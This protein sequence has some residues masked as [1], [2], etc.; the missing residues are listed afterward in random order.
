MHA[1]I[2]KFEN[3]HKNLV[4]VPLQFAINFIFHFTVIKT[5][6][7]RI[8]NSKLEKYVYVALSRGT[9]PIT[10][11]QASQKKKNRQSSAR[12]HQPSARISRIHYKPITKLSLA[13]SPVGR[14][15]TAAASAQTDG[16]KRVHI[17]KTARLSRARYRSAKTPLNCTNHR[18]MTVLGGFRYLFLSW[19]NA[20][21]L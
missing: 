1:F 17:V 10:A 7:D 19:V 4:V 14:A 11:K 8:I 12:S 2:R 18:R 3:K 9:I 13:G 21:Q 15:A 20:P 6:V 16:Q 5:F